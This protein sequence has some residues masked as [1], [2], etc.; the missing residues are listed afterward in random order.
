MNNPLGKFVEW[1]AEARA[2]TAI[3]EP[4][5]MTLATASKDGI[6][7]ARIVLLKGHDERGFVFYTNLGSRKAEELKE[8]PHAAL[9]F[10]WLPLARQ[11]RIEGMAEQVSDKEADAYYASRPLISRIGAWAS[12]QSRPL[13]SRETL[14]R[15]VEALQEQYSEHAPPPR[16]PHWSGFRVIPNV[17]E[18]WQEGKFRLHEREVYTRSNNDWNVQILYP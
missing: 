11:L 9:C 5:A 10:A 15:K 8:N 17:I 18:F 16:P 7:S 4:T 13:A 12:E 3:T 6:P 14:M 1:L 2:H